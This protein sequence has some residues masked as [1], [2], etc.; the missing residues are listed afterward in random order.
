MCVR[1]FFVGFF[2]F[3][4][5]GVPLGRVVGD[6]VTHTVSHKSRILTSSFF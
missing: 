3:W 5:G 2:F 1:F 4:G 6:C